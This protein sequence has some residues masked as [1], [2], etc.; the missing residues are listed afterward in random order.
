MHQSNAGVKRG[1]AYEKEWRVGATNSITDFSPNSIRTERC[2]FISLRHLV[3]PNGFTKI[4]VHLSALGLSLTFKKWRIPERLRN[5]SP[6]TCQRRLIFL[7]GLRASIDTD[8][9]GNGRTLALWIHQ[10]FHGKYTFPVP[11]L[12]MSCGTGSESDLASLIQDQER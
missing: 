10:T 9:Q 3:L 11:L 8:F 4:N 7:T 2:T 5:T 12:M 1:R 6:N